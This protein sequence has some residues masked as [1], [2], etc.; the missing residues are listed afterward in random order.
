MHSNVTIK[1]VSWLWPPVYNGSTDS[2]TVYRSYVILLGYLLPSSVTRTASP[3]CFITFERNCII[4]R[5]YLRF[6]I[7]VVYLGR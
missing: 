7:N 2:N 5:F 6:Y 4:P 1:N 3:P